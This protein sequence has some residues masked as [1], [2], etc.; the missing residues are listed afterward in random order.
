[1]GGIL[2]GLSLDPWVSMAG[3]GAGADTGLPLLAPFIGVAAV[4]R[5][6][7]VAEALDVL[8]VEVERG[9]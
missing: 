9:R 1:M 5:L 2:S 8:E 4:S 3:A 6:V 7:A